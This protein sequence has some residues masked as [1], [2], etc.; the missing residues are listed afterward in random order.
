MQQISVS[1]TP[2]ISVHM[3]YSEEEP[4]IN[5]VHTSKKG[6]KIMFLKFLLHSSHLLH[7]KQFFI[8]QNGR[9][10]GSLE[11]LTEG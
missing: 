3:H 5:Y 6:K 9:T 1:E 7:M 8:F 11:T 10:Q 4:K 2:L